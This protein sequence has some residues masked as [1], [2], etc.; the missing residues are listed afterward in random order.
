MQ[1]ILEGTVL[2]QIGNNYIGCQQNISSAL[3]WKKKDRKKKDQVRK[4][5]SKKEK[6]ERTYNAHYLVTA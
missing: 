5:V 1:T 3:L 2:S 4:S 6:K